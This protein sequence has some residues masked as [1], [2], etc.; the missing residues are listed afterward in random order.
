MRKKQTNENT[1]NLDHLLNILE[2][3]FLVA[4]FMTKRVKQQFRASCQKKKNYKCKLTRQKHC[5]NSNSI[6]NKK[7]K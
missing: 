4:V 2:G 6:N 7:E 1:E 5:G 3:F